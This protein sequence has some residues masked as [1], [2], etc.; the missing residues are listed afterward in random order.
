[1]KTIFASLLVLVGLLN[2]AKADLAQR[3]ASLCEGHTDS[4]QVLVVKQ[5]IAN[6]FGSCYGRYKDKFCTFQYSISSEKS[7][8]NF[9]CENLNQTF[10]SKALSY[11]ITGL[12]KSHSGKSSIIIDTKD[13][14]ILSSN[15]VTLNLTLENGKVMDHK[16]IFDESSGYPQM[17]N[18]ACI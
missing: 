8:M 13:Y 9:Y 5:K 14:L 3:H 6:S 7:T 2:T 12:V 16:V 10:V 15:V 18:T 4:C 1:M 11:K 17:T